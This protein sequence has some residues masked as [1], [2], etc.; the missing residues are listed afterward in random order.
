M[1]KLT[2]YWMDVLGNFSRQQS[3]FQFIAQ[4]ATGSFHIYWQW[5]VCTLYMRERLKSSYP[6]PLLI[7]WFDFVWNE[8][9]DPCQCHL[10]CARSRSRKISLFSGLHC[11][12]CGHDRH[13][14]SCCRRFVVTCM[15]FSSCTVSQSAHNRMYW[16]IISGTVCG[17]TGL[18]HLWESILF[19]VIYV[20]YVAVVVTISC[21]ARHRESRVC[22]NFCIHLI[23]F[24][25]S[26]V[27]AFWPDQHHDNRRS[28][29]SWSMGVSM[30]S[31]QWVC[32][33][34]AVTDST[35]S[36]KSMHFRFSVTYSHRIIPQDLRNLVLT[37]LTT[38]MT[39]FP[40]TVPISRFRSL[41][42]CRNH[43]EVRT[44][45][46]W[47]LACGGYGMEMS[48]AEEVNTYTYFVLPAGLH[49]FDSRDR[50]R[51]NAWGT[52]ENVGGF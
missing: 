13:H 46:A 51:R 8:Y 29:N 6:N 17:F 16:E 48:F 26:K 34:C 42:R 40:L 20:V 47:C 27:T 1:A 52:R 24:G 36:M 44:N 23:V 43:H 19:L 50:P 49:S 39:M 14:C 37:D 21:V 30:M 33:V 9:S 5:Y 35:D 22:V 2:W 25:W 45:F 38:T 11:L 4:R 32:H 3:W 10:C 41:V 12:H 15:C 7:F 28:A 18:I 31:L